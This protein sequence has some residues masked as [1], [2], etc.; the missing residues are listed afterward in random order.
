MQLILWTPELR[1]SIRKMKARALS[2][3]HSE[4]LTHKN[5]QT[6]VDRSLKKKPSEPK[7]YWF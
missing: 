3:S 2:N 7:E 5:H 4:D 6:Q 1:I